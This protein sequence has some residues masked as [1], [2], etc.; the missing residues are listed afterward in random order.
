MTCSKIV[1]RTSCLYFIVKELWRLSSPWLN[2]LDY[3]LW[4]NVIGVSQITSK[5]KIIA[6][7]EETAAGDSLTGS[8]I[9]K[10]VKEFSKRLKLCVVAK[11][12][13]FLIITVSFKLHIRH[14]RTDGRT[15]RHPRAPTMSATIAVVT[16]C[17]RRCDSSTRCKRHVSVRSPVFYMEFD[18]NGSVVPQVISL[19][20]T[21]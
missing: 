13:H 3:H 19:A 14:K 4:G 5:T 8:P 15:K 9:Y 20:W 21:T 18:A 17:R 1:H 10:A 7:M 6:E 2:P 16:P 12:G 11:D